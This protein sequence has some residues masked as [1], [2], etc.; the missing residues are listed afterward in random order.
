[1]TITLVEFPSISEGDVEALRVFATRYLRGSEIVTGTPTAVEQTSAD[2]TIGTP[3]LNAATIE[4]DG[5]THP[6]GAVVT[7]PIQGQ[8][9]ATGSYSV[10]VT[11]ATDAT[12]TKNFLC[13]FGVDPGV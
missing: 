12:R 1:M 13:K 6:I 2:L 4:Y 10:L 9:A 11:V 3:T 7:V 5:I 8:L